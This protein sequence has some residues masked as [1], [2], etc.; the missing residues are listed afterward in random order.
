[1]T[2]HW[3]PD[4]LA[5]INTAEELEIASLRQDGTLRSARTIWVVRQGDDLYVRSVHGR[6]SAWFRGVVDRHLGHIEA[7]GVKKDVTFEEIAADQ[8]VHTAIDAAYRAKYK[9]YAKSIVDSTVTPTARSATIKL[10]PR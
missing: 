8:D 7:G 9:R 5:K 2:S 6:T 3:T 10:V 4:E 1:M